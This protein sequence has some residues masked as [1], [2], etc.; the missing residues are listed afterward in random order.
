MFDWIACFCDLIRYKFDV[1]FTVIRSGRF[2]LNVKVE[3]INELDIF[4]Y[5]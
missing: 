2:P 5:V 1:N 3:H 4:D